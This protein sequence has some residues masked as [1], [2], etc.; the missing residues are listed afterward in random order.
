MIPL[1]LFGGLEVLSALAVPCGL[2]SGA[3]FVCVVIVSSFKAN[4]H[5]MEGAG[6]KKN[7]TLESLW[8]PGS[9]SCPRRAVRIGFSCLI[10]LC[11]HRFVFYTNPH[12]MEG[13]G[14]KKNDTLGSL[15][16]PGSY[17]CPRRAVRIGFSCLIC[18]CRH[19]FV[20]Y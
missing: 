8:W 15:W 9:S 1:S 2:A 17:S 16:W 10:C 5:G 12:G 13:A 14:M 11:R 3:S 19:R 4:P 6:M 18:L 20:F 7:D